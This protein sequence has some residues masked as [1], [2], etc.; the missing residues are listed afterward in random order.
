ML[1]GYIRVT[2]SDSRQKADHGGPKRIS[3]A[4][5]KHALTPTEDL[6][7]NLQQIL[8]SDSYNLPRWH[9]LQLTVQG[10]EA[11]ISVRRRE[12]CRMKRAV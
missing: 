1:H 11:R 10:T 5:R 3:K 8:S 7:G 6:K 12:N 2:I 9:H 4:V